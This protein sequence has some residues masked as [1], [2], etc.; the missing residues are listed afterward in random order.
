MVSTT[1]GFYPGENIAHLLERAAG[2]G[3]RGVLYGFTA[4]AGPT[5]HFGGFLRTGDCQVT[6]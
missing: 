6:G 3:G 2:A 5:R 1:L 4:V